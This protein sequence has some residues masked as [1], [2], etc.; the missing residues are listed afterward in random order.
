MDAWNCAQGVTQRWR[1]HIASPLHATPSFL[2]RAVCNHFR[3]D[4]KTMLTIAHGV[5]GIRDRVAKQKPYRAHDLRHI[6]VLTIRF[7]Y[8]PSQHFPISKHHIQESLLCVNR[9]LNDDHYRHGRHTYQ[10]HQRTGDYEASSPRH[11]IPGVHAPYPPEYLPQSLR[12]SLSVPTSHVCALVPWET[13][14]KDS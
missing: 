8:Q 7:G 13:V 3:D 11:S 10:R 1:A 6:Y 2:F 4:Y 5:L 12:P 14:W 9:V